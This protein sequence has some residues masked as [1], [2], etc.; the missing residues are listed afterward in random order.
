[1]VILRCSNSGARIAIEG[2]GQ[3]I[4]GN[5]PKRQLISVRYQHRVLR[6]HRGGRMFCGSN[7]PRGNPHFDA[8]S[9][10]DQRA[11]LVGYTKVCST[12]IL[13]WAVPSIAGIYLRWDTTAKVILI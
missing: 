7:R 10:D 5:V 1:M 9:A 8:Q 12:L 11:G 6:R 4:G 2:Q 3:P 13:Y